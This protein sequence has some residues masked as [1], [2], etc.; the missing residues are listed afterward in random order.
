MFVEAARRAHEKACGN[1]MPARMRHAGLWA[2]HG[3]GGGKRIGH[4]AFGMQHGHR[5]SAWLAGYPVRG[6]MVWA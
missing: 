5:A 6:S 1:A 3:Q 4:H 2:E